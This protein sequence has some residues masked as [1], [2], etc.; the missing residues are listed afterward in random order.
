MAVLVADSLSVQGHNLSIYYAS[1]WQNLMSTMSESA[2]A[3]S[4]E[5]LRITEHV[6]S[7]GGVPCYMMFQSYCK[8]NAGGPYNPPDFFEMVTE[9]KEAY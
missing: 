4:L 3:A 8:G 6:S 1:G 9:K 5:N 2:A 7:L